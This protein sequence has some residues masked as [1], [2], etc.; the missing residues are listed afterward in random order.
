MRSEH[1]ERLL[2]ERTA[3]LARKLTL[4]MESERGQMLVLMKVA[5]ERF[6]IAPEAVRAVAELRRVT[7]LP[8][9]PARVLGL[10]SRAG[11]IIPVFDL[12]AVLG[13]PLTNLPEYGR[14]VLLGGDDDQ[15]AIAV[16]ELEGNEELRDGELVELPQTASP[17]LRRFARGLVRG[18]TV[19][20]DHV[21]LLA[22]ELLLVD[23][24]LPR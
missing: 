16:D 7:P 2:D 10:T 17:G 20:L 23:V 24:A 19:V 4:R 8:H 13:L 14:I 1:D 12:R 18:S 5:G 22:S 11:A 3:A 6:A 21:A 9:M 15:A